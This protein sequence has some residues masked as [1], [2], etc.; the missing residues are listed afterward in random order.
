ML[1]DALEDESICLFSSPPADPIIDE[2]QAA[3]LIAEY[4][5]Q[6]DFDDAV[7][8][9]IDA[10]EDLFEK[11]KAKLPETEN[12]KGIALLGA[13][14]LFDNN[15]KTLIEAQADSIFAQYGCRVF[16]IIDQLSIEQMRKSLREGEYDAE[17][18]VFLL[19]SSSDNSYEIISTVDLKKVF[20]EEAKGYI[21]EKYIGSLENGIGEDAVKG[22]FQGC[23][24]LFYAAQKG[25]YI[26]DSHQSSMSLILIIAA[27]IIPAAALIYLFNRIMKRKVPDEQE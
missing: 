16:A 1:L 12:T 11:N 23:E 3:M 2:T 17:Q 8:A 18:A 26:E 19:L 22:F 21:A 27:I 7:F 15:A 9:C 5:A 14:K 25:D 13:E 24:E 10:A 6:A 20:S 4:D